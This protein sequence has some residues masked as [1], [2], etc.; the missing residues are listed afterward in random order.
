MIWTVKIEGDDLEGGIVPLPDSLLAKLGVD[1]G[2]SLHLS[3][4]QHAD[5]ARYLVLSKKLMPDRTHTSDE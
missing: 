3:Q 5:G 1:I 4:Q 2:D